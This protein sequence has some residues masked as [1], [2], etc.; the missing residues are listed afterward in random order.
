L[1]NT[2][3]LNIRYTSKEGEV[4]MDMRDI[5]AKGKE[6]AEKAMKDAIAEAQT[7]DDFKALFECTVEQ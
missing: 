2:Q 7:T 3:H 1:R 4:I 5:L 6:L